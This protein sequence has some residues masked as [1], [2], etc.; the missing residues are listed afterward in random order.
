MTVG[1]LVIT[2]H[3]KRSAFIALMLLDEQQEEHPVCKKLSDE[4]LLWLTVWS[5]V[6][7]TCI[8]SS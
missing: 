1:R 6:Q 3:I 2:L 4:V 8:S 7:M 5:K